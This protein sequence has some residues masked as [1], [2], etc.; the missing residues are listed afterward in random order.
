MDYVAPSSGNPSGTNLQTDTWDATYTFAG[1]GFY[2]T[3]DPLVA[4]TIQAFDATTGS[5]QLSQ[6]SGVNGFYAYSIGSNDTFYVDP[7]LDNEVLF[8]A[9][10]A[11]SSS[12]STGGPT[13]GSGTH[14]NG[15]VN[16]NGCVYLVS[17]ATPITESGF[18][19]TTVSDSLATDSTGYYTSSYVGGS[20]FNLY[21]QVTGSAS[22]S[23]G[24][25]NSDAP[26]SA[27]GASEVVVTF[28]YDLPTSSTGTPE[29]ASLLL[30]GTGL[31]FVA[32]KLRRNKTAA[33]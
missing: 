24:S 15:F 32:A 31:S 2:N 18:N 6:Q 13:C 17:S 29:P 27:T 28:T 25:P 12:V 8:D 21:E 3:G 11:S 26:N 30:L 20:S 10:T 22:I 1:Y 4:S 33:K 16:S 23:G 14:P 7:T 9:S 5:I 19:N